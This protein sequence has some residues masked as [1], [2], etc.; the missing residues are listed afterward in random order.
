MDIWRVALKEWAANPLFGYGNSIFDL[1]FRLRIKML[2]AVHAHNQFIQ[3]L[4]AAGLVG[5]S[6]ILALLTMLFIRSIRFAGAT[7]GVTV[8]LSVFLLVRS[9]TEVPLRP[10]SLLAGE[11]IFL[12]AFIAII[13]REQ[14]RA[15]PSDVALAQ[16]GHADTRRRSPG[17]PSPVALAR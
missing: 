11:F 16:D 7:R 13:V 17:F 15:V 10:S 2:Y 12:L 14:A 1:A 8:A 4:G 9:I 3:A 6:G 5:L